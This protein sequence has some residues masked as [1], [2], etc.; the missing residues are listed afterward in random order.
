MMLTLSDARLQCAVSVRAR[1]GP[2]YPYMDMALH[3]EL[4]VRPQA[5]RAARLAELAS[6]ISDAVLQPQAFGRLGKIVAGV[7]DVLE[8]VR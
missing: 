8:G 3:T 5:P 6:V 4:V 2:Q 7:R 1:V